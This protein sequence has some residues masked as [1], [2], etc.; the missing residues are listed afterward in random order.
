MRPRPDASGI[1]AHKY[2]S[3]S[4][5]GTHF[6]TGCHTTAKSPRFKPMMPTAIIAAAK[7]Q[8]PRHANQGAR[9]S[10]FEVIGCVESTG[11]P[12]RRL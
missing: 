8:R 4:R 3:N 9:G 1:K 5:S 2:T 6:G 7:T 12:G 10:V 11:N